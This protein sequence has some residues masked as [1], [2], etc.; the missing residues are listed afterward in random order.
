MASLRTR[1][2]AALALVGLTATFAAAIAIT[3]E[4]WQEESQSLPAAV[5][6]EAFRLSEV[7]GSQEL[8]VPAVG[9]RDRFSLLFDQDGTLVAQR[10]TVDEATIDAGLEAWSETVDFDVGVSF[11]EPATGGGQRFISA[12]AC[13]N[14]TV[15]D[16]AVAGS[17]T[18]EFADYA[19]PRLGWILGLPV[20]VGLAGLVLGRWL[21]GRA[22]RPVEAMRAELEEITGSSLERRVPVAR[23]G[24]EIQHLG[25]TLNTTL[26][27]LQTAG[28]AVERFAA[29][30]AHELRSPITGARAA[31]E[32]RSDGDD[33]LQAG[34]AELDRAGALI[35]DLL[36]LA[37]HDGVPA[38]RVDVDVDEVVQS[39]V[40]TGRTRHPEVAFTVEADP[41]RLTGDPAAITRLVT[42][43]VENAAHYGSGRV[44]VRV[45]RAGGVGDVL[46][47]AA[48]ITVDDDGPGIPAPERKRIFERFSR[49]DESRSRRSGGTGL[50]LAIA[51]DIAADHG[52]SISVGD[53]DLGGARFTVRLPTA[54]A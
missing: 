19:V 16:T 17:S 44:L 31:M 34:V 48:A 33:L 40:A 27:R 50:G 39:V 43:L 22:L 46:G 47:G 5:E 20:A 23:S 29:D 21:V 11:V 6:L 38:R 54:A 15:C 8:S 9:G 26:D 18:V 1:L 32:L 53:A 24:D 35:D 7:A 4:R 10:G 49:L 51:A 12:A 2:G 45:V 52:G 13:L 3:Y 14:T 37:R 42:N 25:E 41:V 36:F 30:A 28:T